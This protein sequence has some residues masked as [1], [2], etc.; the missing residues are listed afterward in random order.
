MLCMCALIGV[1]HKE[2]SGCNPISLLKCLQGG[3]K[4]ATLGSEKDVPHNVTIADGYPNFTVMIAAV[5]WSKCILIALE[6]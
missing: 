2:A 6:E 5:H 4:M 3:S 1:S